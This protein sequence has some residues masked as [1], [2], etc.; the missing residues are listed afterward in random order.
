MQG[1]NYDVTKGDNS[2][3]PPGALSPG[4]ELSFSN[5]MEFAIRPA[6]LDCHAAPMNRGGVNLETY[7]NV[8]ALKNE[9]AS[10]LSSRFMPDSQG[11]SM[12]DE[13]RSFVLRWITAGAPRL[14]GE[15]K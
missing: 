9:I 5:A 10:A 7:E 4:A 1:C 2:T 14:P 12:S 15:L 8:L 11:R 3:S 13:Q 6:C